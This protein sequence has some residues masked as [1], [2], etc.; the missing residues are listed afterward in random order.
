MSFLQ[1]YNKIYFK[2]SSYP[3]RLTPRRQTMHRQ[4]KIRATLAYLYILS[5]AS[6]FPNL[7][8]DCKLQTA[9]SLQTTQGPQG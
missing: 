6:G 7:L 9:C 3:L 2:S 4:L 1:R 5:L 8:V